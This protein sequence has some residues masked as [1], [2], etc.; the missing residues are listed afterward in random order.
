MNKAEIEKR[1]ESLKEE[2]AGLEKALKEKE[3]PPMPPVKRPHELRLY[4]FAGEAYACGNRGITP[5]NEKPLT[6]RQAWLLLECG[7]GVSSATLEG[8]WVDFCTKYPKDD[9]LK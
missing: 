3:I 8:D 7:I 6:P 4:I 5:Y 2:L 9:Y 1:V